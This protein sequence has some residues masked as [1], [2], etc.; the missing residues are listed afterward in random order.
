[1]TGR[2]DEWLLVV[3]TGMTNLASGVV[4]VALP[5]LAVRLTNSPA[6]A[7]GVL[8]ALSLPWLVTAL[9][10][11]VL[12]DRRNRRSLMVAA[13]GAR[14]A[15]IA[16]LLVAVWLQ[17]ITLPVIYL[18]AAV[19]GLAEVVALIAGASIVPSVVPRNRWQ[20][21]SS[22]IT[23]VEYLSNGFLG[24][25]VGGFL[26]AAGFTFALGTTGLVYLAGAVLLFMMAGDFAVK[27]T[28]S[29]RPVRAEIREGLQFLWQHR[30]LRGMALLITG[31]AACW[32][33]WLA[34]IPLYAINQLG[35]NPEQYGFLFTSLGAGGVVG[36]L[37]AGWTN[38]LLGRRW[39]MFVDIIGSFTLV[40]A[41]AVLP[42][43]SS[44]A[45]PLGVAAFVA[46]A[47]GTMWTVNARVI[48]QSFVPQHLLGRFSSANRLI[49]WGSVPV[50]AA[51][52]GALAE[53]MGYRVAFGVFAVLCAMLVIP[54]LRVV[55]VQA[56]AP[57]DQ[58]AETEVIVT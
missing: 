39:S 57:V 5:L 20:V 44:S 58:P 16:A 6:L 8:I 48:T 51:L 33:A 19:L 43:S 14:V 25:P 30:L 36:A 38:R 10:V 34:L 26:V 52:A 54:F 23:T 50:S 53:L 4:K 29:P 32:G 56:I 37:A 28:E 17:V 35:L 9:H 49:A 12:V 22:R 13:E 21:V 55:T 15:S 7:S 41:P 31:M 24:A 1:M 18:F 3:F 47:G 45:W 27:R 46:G 2:R 40:A 11:G 42:A